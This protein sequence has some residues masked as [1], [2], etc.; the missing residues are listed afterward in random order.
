MDGHHLRSVRPRDSYCYAYT[1]AYREGAYW[2][3]T[4]GH[5]NTARQVYM[6]LTGLFIVEDEDERRLNEA[7]GVELGE[8]D[9]PL[10]I[11]DKYIDGEGN[12]VYD[13]AEM[14]RSMG[15]TGKV[16]LIKV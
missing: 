9:L 6:G 2:Y 14:D 10:V 4:H 7:L 16:I 5:G 8:T 13:P 1:V 12:L 3:H 15:Y 11:P